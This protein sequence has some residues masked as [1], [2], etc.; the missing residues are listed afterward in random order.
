MKFDERELQEL[1]RNGRQP[2]EREEDCLADEDWPRLMAGEMSTVERTRA[3]THMTTCTPCAD[4]YRALHALR[5]W[6]DEAADA[7][8]PAA[9][10]TD[11]TRA[12]FSWTSG[13]TAL[14]LAASLAIVIAQGVALVWLLTTRRADVARLETQVA[15]HE[16]DLA[17][18]RSAL[19][20]LQEQRRTASTTTADEVALRERVAQL[21]TP[22]L[23]VPIVDL[24]PSGAT[25]GGGEPAATVDVPRGALFVTLILN[26]TPLTDRSTLVVRILGDG[27]REVW[28]G[29]T[30]R[31]GGAASLNVTLPRD[32]VPDGRYVIRLTAE[33][34]GRQTDVA[35]YAVR[36][37]SRTPQP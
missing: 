28:T 35:E 19:R 22:Q 11:R 14:A 5:P 3:A 27:G 6:A 2:D 36:V 12:S 18:A 21:S 9:L 17:S 34:N 10:R 26:F 13:R 20:E 1:W 30:G 4:R 37:R 24:D 31:D 7:L 15:S 25:R 16:Q 33:R 29:R 32:S 8:A 23:E